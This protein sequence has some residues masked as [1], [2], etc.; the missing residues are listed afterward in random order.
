MCFFGDDFLVIFF[1]LKNMLLTFTLCQVKDQNGD[2]FCWGLVFVRHYSDLLCFWF[3]DL[4]F[5]KHWDYTGHRKEHT[6]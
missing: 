2:V 3:K 5:Q 6:F 4:E 1:C